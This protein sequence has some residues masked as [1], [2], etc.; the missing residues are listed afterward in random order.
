MQKGCTEA[1]AQPAKN[2]CLVINRMTGLES[3]TVGGLAIDSS[4]IHV[5]S[6][7]LSYFIVEPLISAI[8]AK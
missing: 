5:N 8:M 2:G 6:M 3:V 4:K 1:S 7:I